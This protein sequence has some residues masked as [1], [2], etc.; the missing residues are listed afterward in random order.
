MRNCARSIRRATCATVTRFLEQRVAVGGLMSCFRKEQ[1]EPFRQR[2]DD[3]EKRGKVAAET[4]T[5]ITDENERLEYGLAAF[6]NLSKQITKWIVE[7]R[8]AFRRR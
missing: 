5:S 7:M 3:L 8:K 4:M 1:Q 6:K 2:L